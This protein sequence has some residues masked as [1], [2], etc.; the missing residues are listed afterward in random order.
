[1]S[2][3]LNT[4]GIHQFI[5]IEQDADI[6]IIASEKDIELLEESLKGY[7]EKNVVI[8]EDSVGLPPSPPPSSGYVELPNRLPLGLV[9]GFV[10]QLIVLVVGGT[11]MWSSMN[12]K[13]EVQSSK[14]SNLEV[15]MYT[16]SEAMIRQEYTS[17][18]L[19]EMKDLI[20]KKTGN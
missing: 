1:M 12:A 9:L 10:T 3:E 8:I 15:N 13:L 14:I 6:E 2:E 19:A 5:H 20:N 11:A 16:K 4:K 7:V 17:Q 18:N